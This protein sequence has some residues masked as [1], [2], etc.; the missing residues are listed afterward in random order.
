MRNPL[1]PGQLH[2]LTVQ[3]IRI[4]RPEGMYGKQ[5]LTGTTKVEVQADAILHASGKLHTGFE[6]AIHFVPEGFH[7]FLQPRRDAVAAGN[8]NTAFRFPDVQ[9]FKI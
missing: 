4:F 9:V 8:Y 5:Y 7:L 2:Q 1:L 6:H 3:H